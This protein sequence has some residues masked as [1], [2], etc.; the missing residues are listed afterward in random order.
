MLYCRFWRIELDATRWSV[1]PSFETSTHE[2]LPS[3]I[4]RFLFI[5]FF[6]CIL[7]RSFSLVCFVPLTE[8][9]IAFASIIRHTSN[10][11][12]I[13]TH[14]HTSN[15]MVSTHTCTSTHPPCGAGRPGANGQTDFESRVCTDRW[16]HSSAPPPRHQP[17]TYTSIL[18][19]CVVFRMTIW[20][21][22]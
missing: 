22:F 15:D 19:V 20:I 12:K 11:I 5:L 9:L 2:P 13:N 4:I 10:R 8:S 18:S 14:T 17:H 3:T 6:C 1:R 16:R 7:L 21:L